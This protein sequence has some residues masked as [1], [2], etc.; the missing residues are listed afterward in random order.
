MSVVG[1]TVQLAAEGWKVGVIEMGV[2]SSF[3]EFQAT[4][5][6][7]VTV[8][9]LARE[10]RDV[11]KAALQSATDVQSVWGSGSLRRSTQ[12]QPV[13]DVDLVVEFDATQHPTWGTDGESAIE[14]I[15]RCRDLVTEMLSLASGT[16]ARLVRQ[17][18]TADRNRAAK[19]FID[20]PDDPDAFTVDVMPALRQQDGILIPFKSESRWTL[21]DPEFLIDRVAERHTEWNRFRPMVRVLKYWAHRQPFKIKSLVMEVLALECL[22]SAGN[23]A[24]AVSE[25]FTAASQ[26]SLWVVDPAGLSGEIQPSLDTTQLRRALEDSSQSATSALRAAAD[27]N[28]PEA[29]R[30]WRNVFGAAF[31]VVAGAGGAAATARPV[32]DSPQG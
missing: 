3:D 27:G 6:A 4:V 18:D 26:H 31:P 16:H 15:E 32:K 5:D 7:D 19:C 8:V 29:T 23:R 28:Q 20:D 24:T 21:A 25:F 9:N 30:L 1:P 22:P 17:V 14:A 13:H 2:S 11:F 12:L 10:R